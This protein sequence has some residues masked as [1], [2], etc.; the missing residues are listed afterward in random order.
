MGSLKDAS[1]YHSVCPAPH[2]HAPVN[3]A[4]SA[5]RMSYGLLEPCLGHAIALFVHGHPAVP[6]GR[7]R[8]ASEFSAAGAGSGLTMGFCAA[9]AHSAISANALYNTG[10]PAS[11]NLLTSS[12][13]RQIIFH[14]AACPLPFFWGAGS[15]QDRVHLRRAMTFVLVTLA[16]ASSCAASDWRRDSRK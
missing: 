2:T 6:H 1:S 7:S 12:T 5:F 16:G 9:C 8:P 4:F 13:L 14:P 3:M 10:Y 15:C 11:T